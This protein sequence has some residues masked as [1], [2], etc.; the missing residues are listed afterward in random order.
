M[1]IR[2]LHILRLMNCAEEE[3]Y[4][5][6]DDMD[7][8]RLMYPEADPDQSYSGSDPSFN[9]SSDQSNDSLQATAGASSEK[10]VIVQ[11]VYPNGENLDDSLQG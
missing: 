3:D 7:P 10:A 5:D 11:Y 4:V 8:S 6:E 1:S 9:K 2:D